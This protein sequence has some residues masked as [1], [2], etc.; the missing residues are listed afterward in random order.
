MK[1]RKGNKF[2][3]HD[4]L[5][6]V[7]TFVDHSNLSEKIKNNIDYTYVNQLYHHLL[8]GGGLVLVAEN[9]D[10]VVGM[11]AGIKAPNIWHQDDVSLREIIFFVH[12]K[13]RNGRTAY[14]LITEY[15]K[16]A[17]KLL[18]DGMI[19]AYTMTKTEHLDQLDF[20]RFGYNKVEET[21]AVGM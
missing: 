1:I 2:D 3:I 6:M 21:W 16:E 19:S 4:I 12:E 9:D 15:N 11:I 18:D 5:E 20:S 14:K 8:L 17:Q 7:E 10:G 13:Y